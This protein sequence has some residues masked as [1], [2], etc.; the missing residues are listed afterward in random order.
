M[1]PQPVSERSN[2]TLRQISKDTVWTICN[3]FVQEDQKQFVEPNAISIAEAYFSKE[4]WF[5]GIYAEETPVGFAMLEEQPAKAR[6]FLWRFMIDAR[7]QKFGFGK[8]AIGLLVEHVK[9]L[10]NATELL[11]S[12][13]QTEG[14]PQDFYE[15]IGFKLTGE[16]DDGEAVMRL[17][18]QVEQD[19]NIWN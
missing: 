10:P 14:G 9:T 17:L 12:V 3:L 8:Q 4:A 15:N 5:R 6:Y 1:E 7:Y 2:V 16:Y 19:I 18:F 11:T 13:V